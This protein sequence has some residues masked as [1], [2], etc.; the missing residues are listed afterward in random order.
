MNLPGAD[1][2]GGN[3]PRQGQLGSMRAT[4][5]RGARGGQRVRG[6]LDG[7]WGQI[8][9]QPHEDVLHAREVLGTSSGLGALQDG[10]GAGGSIR[11]QGGRGGD[12]RN[13]SLQQNCA[14]GGTSYHTRG[15]STPAA[16]GTAAVP[17]EEQQQQVRTPI[18]SVTQ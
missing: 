9:L 2:A 14:A 8:S 18:A 17:S 15:L 4:S 11:C 16:D 5:T 10:A 13:E 6:L 7:L 12:E 1:K 3:L